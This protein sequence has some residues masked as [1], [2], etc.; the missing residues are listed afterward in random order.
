MWKRSWT[1]PKSQKIRGFA[2]RVC[3]LV[4][5]EVTVIKIS[6]TGP[7]K[8]ELR[9]YDNNMHNKPDRQRFMGSQTYT[10]NNR[11]LRKVGLGIGGLSQGRAQQPV[12]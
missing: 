6:P 4:I 1:E 8:C 12:F 7:S 11:Q 2:V 3:F 5:P 10:K 9:K